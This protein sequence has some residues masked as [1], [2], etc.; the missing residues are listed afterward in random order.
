MTM[1]PDDPQDDLGPSA[2][3]GAGS[4][5]RIDVLTIFPEMVEGF[6]S[7]S[8]LGKARQ[9]GL[10]DLRV[11]DLRSAATDPHRSVDDSPFGGGAGMVLKAE[12]I[13]NT[14]ELVAPPRPLLYLSPAGRVFD[15]AFAAELAALDGFSLLCGRYEG[16]D[17]RVRE[18]LIDGEVSI[19]DYVLAGGEVAAAVILEAVCR[20][21][22]GLVG[23]HESVEDDSFSQ[24]LLEYPHY[25]RPA[26]YRGWDVPDVLTSGDHARVARWRRA[27]ALLRT[28]RHRRDLLT[29]RGG[30]T[31]DEQRLLAEFDLLHTVDRLIETD[32]GA[33]E[34]PTGGTGPENP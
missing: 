21:V 24:G 31:P 15:Q 23:N 29:A 30:I 4:Q 19:G 18:H 16:V 27:Q 32:G 7:A 12:P 33:G 3:G 22:P 25:T 11:H 14:V 17:E 6:A 8:L 1:G 5:L 20:L 9:R 13:F 34:G 26:S 2:E 10:V 28:A